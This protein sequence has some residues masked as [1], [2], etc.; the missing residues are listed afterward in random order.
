MGFVGRNRIVVTSRLFCAFAVLLV[1]AVTACS[2]DVTL[3]EF[4]K[5]APDQAEVWNQFENQQD[6]LNELSVSLR[7]ARSQVTDLEIERENLIADVAT[8]QDQI[9]DLKSSLTDLSTDSSQAKNRIA[10]LLVN[11][12]SL[13]SDLA[14]V[15]DD[16]ARLVGDQEIVPVEADIRIVELPKIFP[17]LDNR[18]GGAFYDS[19]SG[20]IFFGGWVQIRPAANLQN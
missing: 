4:D 16:L 11:R 8:A 12:A 13:S 18:G 19:T 1:L 9:G 5:V 6:S 3:E 14:Q 20:S 10:E 15:R 2:E 7:D 17:G